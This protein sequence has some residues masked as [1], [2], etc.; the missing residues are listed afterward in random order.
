MRMKYIEIIRKHKQDS[1]LDTLHA[2]QDIDGYV[3][4]EAMDTLAGEFG[5]TPAKIYETASFYSMIRFAPQ[6]VTTIQICRSA[7]CHV[8]GAGEIIKDLEN[9][10]GIRMG[11]STPDGKIKLEYVECLG[12]CQDSPSVLIN[13]VLHTNTD[14]GKILELAGKGR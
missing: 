8:A 2:L 1:F 13:G 9:A 3:T 6:P 14:A 12:Q 10:L 5:S 7:P 4:P 11:E